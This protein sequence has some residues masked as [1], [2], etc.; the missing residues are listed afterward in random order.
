MPYSLAA[1][2]EIVAIPG[3]TI[4]PDRV[5]SAMHRPM[6]D[7]YSGELLTVTDEI[8]E[9]LPALARTSSP[10][11]ITVSNGHGAWAM[12][13]SNTLS[14]G[15]RLLVLECGVFAGLW[16]EMATFD[17]LDV[18]MMIADEGAA[19]DPDA[20]EARL[21]AD[22][23]RSIKA[24]LMVQT[25]TASSVRNDVAAVRRALDA[26]DHPAL[27]MVDCI[28]SMGCEC[29]E[30]DAWGVDVTLAAS[31]K[32]LMTPPGLG[33]VWA[34]PRALVAHETADMRTR[35]WDWTFRLQE[36]PQYLR[37]C[38]TAPVSHIFGFREAL[39]MIE[40]EGLEARW[41][42]H[43]TIAAAVRA[44]VD[45]WSAPDALSLFV[46]DPA[47]RGDSVT[48]ITTGAVDSTRLSDIARDGG[49][50]TLGVGLLHLAGCAFRIGHMGHVSAASIL[51]VLGVVE[52]A[53]IAIDAPISGSGV[54]AAATSIAAAF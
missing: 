1:G 42:R 12:A 18:E 25:D 3:P 47:H 28:A 16:G 6:P 2:P 30:M 43:T 46:R 5:L 19:I 44:A 15:D 52:A 50:V 51:G 8:Y 14:R 35:Y 23:E 26:A 7:L 13:L 20:V 34:G 11:L 9:R 41:Q 39:R 17:G 38:G 31:Q 48:T 40:E 27:L 4:V 37:F 49:G 32:G 54:A 29:Y 22:P 21:R 10:G 45:A 36:G 53:L 24:V 33:F